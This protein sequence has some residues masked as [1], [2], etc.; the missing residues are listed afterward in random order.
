[1]RGAKAALGAAVLGTALVS[2]TAASGSHALAGGP[3]EVFATPGTTGTILIT[4][5]IGDYGKTVDVNA[6][7]KVQGNGRYVKVTLKQGTFVIDAVAFNVKIGKLKPSF[8]TA[9][10]SAEGS[11][12]APISLGDGTGLYKG[13]SATLSATAT[14]AFIGPRYTSGKHKGQCNESNS[15]Q[16][17]DQYASIHAAGTVKFG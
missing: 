8:N 14:F 15:A 16:V 6:S 4:G 12:T 2:A 11:G 5:A 13:I 17:L 1:M 3:V 9:T 7:G 10:C